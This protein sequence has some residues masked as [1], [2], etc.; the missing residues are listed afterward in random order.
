ML[1]FEITSTGVNLEY[2]GDYPP[3]KADCSLRRL[4]S[5]V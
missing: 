5:D 1:E 4:V 3:I 2:D